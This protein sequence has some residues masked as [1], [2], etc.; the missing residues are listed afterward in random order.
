MA[1]AGIITS[2]N[3]NEEWLT[4]INAVNGSD[5]LDL[6]HLYELEK[7]VYYYRYPITRPDPK[8]LIL[9]KRIFLRDLNNKAN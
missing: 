8:Q 3:Y 1:Y 4:Q 7:V 5:P 2:E 9:E 6:V